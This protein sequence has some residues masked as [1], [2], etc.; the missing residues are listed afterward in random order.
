MDTLTILTEIINATLNLFL[1]YWL[2]DS[3]FS[4][5]TTLI[6]AITLFLIL[7]ILHIIVL[8][9]LK[10]TILYYFCIFIITFLLSFVFKGKLAHRFI[11]TALFYVLEAA[12]EMIVAIAITSILDLDFNGAKQGILLIVGMLL[13]KF[14]SFLIMMIIKIK[15]ETKMMEIVKSHPISIFIFPASTFF[16]IVLQ[17]A[18]FAYN[19]F[20]NSIVSILVLIC[21]T[22]LIMANVLIFDFINTLYIN[23]VNENKIMIAEELITNQAEHYTTILSHHKSISRMRHDHK[24]FCIGIL[25]ELKN[26]SVDK[27]IEFISN[28]QKLAAQN[29]DV[30][31]DIINAVLMFKSDKARKMGVIINHEVRCLYNIRISSVDLA[32]VLG[33]ALDNAIEATR[34]LQNSFAKQ[35]DVLAVLKNNTILITIKNPVVENIDTEHLYSTKSNKNEHGFGIISIKHITDRYH[36]DVIFSCEDKVFTTSILLHNNDDINIKK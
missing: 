27:A 35:I 5:H 19:P 28:E 10:G 32:I 7:D 20:Q 16:I 8:L 25:H 1:A 26:G 9:F 22:I 30:P 24:N 17:H 21:Y 6:K 11:C 3:F 18:I 4:K 15:K 29:I 14:V 2:F 23:T 34:K 36:G 13:S 31:T 12:I 33:N